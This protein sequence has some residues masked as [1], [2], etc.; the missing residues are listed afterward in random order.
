MALLMSLWR[1]GQSSSRMS[2]LSKRHRPSRIRAWDCQTDE[3]ILRLI[4]AALILTLA[5]LP[6]DTHGQART[7]SQPSSSAARE[8]SPHRPSTCETGLR[9]LVRLKVVTPNIF[10]EA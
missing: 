7:A 6:P 3:E 9:R 10:E 2:R 8:G 4:T 5:V 1:T